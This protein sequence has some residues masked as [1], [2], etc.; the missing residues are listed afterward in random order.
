M[1][2]VTMVSGR[3]QISTAWRFTYAFF[4]DCTLMSCINPYHIT[5]PS[6]WMTTL[7][8]FNTCQRIVSDGSIHLHIIS[9]KYVCHAFRHFLLSIQY[10]VLYV[11]Q[12]GYLVGIQ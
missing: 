9:V 12:V 8:V 11:Q 7:V 1:P 3:P 5:L 4:K 10:I 6:P 2:S